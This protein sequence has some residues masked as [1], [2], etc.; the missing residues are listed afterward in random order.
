ML[1]IGCGLWVLTDSHLSQEA[2]QPMD[3]FVIGHTQRSETLL[4]C[5]GIL[6]VGGQTSFLQRL[7]HCL[8]SCETQE[9]FES[10]GSP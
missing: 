1:T 10:F 5:S 6:Q 3:D 4:A 7:G 8:C 2:E 9:T